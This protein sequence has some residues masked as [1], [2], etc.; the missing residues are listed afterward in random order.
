ML[1]YKII[2]SIE[3]ILLYNTDKAHLKPFLPIDSKGYFVCT[4]NKTINDT[5]TI[6]YRKT[7]AVYINMVYYFRNI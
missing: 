2:T 1:S 5:L 3:F 6:S 7:T 4:C